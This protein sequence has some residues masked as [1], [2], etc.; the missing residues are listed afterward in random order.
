MEGILDKV[1]GHP[2]TAYILGF[3]GLSLLLMLGL[4]SAHKFFTLSQRGWGLATL[5]AGAIGGLLIHITDL[6]TLPSNGGLGG[7]A[8][9]AFVGASAAVAA[10]GFSAIDL[11]AIF[12]M[13]PDGG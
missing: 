12:K 10:T 2:A 7:Y 9:A 1:L 3:G 6:V 13:K 11:R 8:L 5:G 4:N